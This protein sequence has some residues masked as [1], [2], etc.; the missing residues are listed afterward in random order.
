MIRCLLTCVQVFR[1]YDFIAVS[2]ARIR[3]GQIDRVS[4]FEFLHFFM[5]RNLRFFSDFYRFVPS[6]C[7]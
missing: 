2:N 1:L 3:Q 4:R 5:Q 7:K 6:Q